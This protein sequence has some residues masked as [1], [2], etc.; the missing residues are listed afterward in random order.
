MISLR[1]LRYDFGLLSNGFQQYALSYLIGFF[2]ISVSLS[3]LP[4]E[5]ANPLIVLFPLTLC[6]LSHVA[7]EKAD[8]VADRS[9]LEHG[10]YGRRLL[11]RTWTTLIANL[12][13]VASGII[14]LEIMRGWQAAISLAFIA[15]VALVVLVYSTAGTVVAAAI[16]H[17]FVSAILMGFLIFTGGTGPQDNLTMKS[18]LAITGA[19]DLEG[20]SLAALRIAAPWAAAAVLLRKLALGR[21]QLSLPRFS[22]ISVNRVFR[23]PRWAEGNPGFLRITLLAG[24]TSP[25]V[26]GAAFLALAVFTGTTLQIAARF[27]ELNVGKDF[28]YLF[29]GQILLNALPALSLAVSLESLEQADQESFLYKSKRLA[30]LAVTVRLSFS[31]LV[32]TVLITLATIFIA[33]ISL[34]PSEL[35]RTI[36]VEILVVPGLAVLALKLRK[37]VKIPV[38]ISLV[39]FAST[40]IEVVVSKLAPDLRPWLPSSLF[41]SAAGGAGLYVES[42]SLIPPLGWALG[43]VLLVGLGPVFLTFWPRR[44]TS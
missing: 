10:G 22:R 40:F 30:N 25:L 33:S 4:P 17:P 34:E 14:G 18:L 43:F 16:P 27:A 1:S 38:L 20:W 9:V 7:S 23:V 39:S 21:A 5:T 35:L 41:S 8:K 42:P 28:F 19:T 32:G 29:P 11:A 2:A 12:L 36:A 15:G 37:A 26:T 13:L 24:L 31:A 44:K 3:A 6:V